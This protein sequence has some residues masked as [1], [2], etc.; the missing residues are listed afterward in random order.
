VR[1]G[2]SRARGELSLAA[3]PQPRGRRRVR[4][5]PGDRSARA[6]R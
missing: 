2:E 4:R 6:R 3:H 1:G 5:S